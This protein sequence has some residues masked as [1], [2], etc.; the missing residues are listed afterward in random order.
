MKAR[1]VEDLQAMLDKLRGMHSC[2]CGEDKGH[3]GWIRCLM[4]SETWHDLGAK[5]KGPA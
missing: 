5:E 1:S 2:F 4:E 3:T